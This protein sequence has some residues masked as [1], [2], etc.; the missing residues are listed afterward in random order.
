MIIDVFAHYISPTISKMIE[1]G[2]YARHYRYPAQN[3]D[4]EVRIALMDKYEIDIQAVSQTSPVLMGF[5]PSEAAEICQVSNDDNYRLCQAYPNRFVNIGMISLLDITSALQELERCVSDL[6]CRGITISSNQEGKGLDSPDYY[7]FYE[8]IIKYDLPILIHPSHWESYPLVDMDEGWR[9]MHIFGWPFDTTQA[10]WR[11]IMG[12]VIDRFPALKVVTHHMG[13]MLPYFV[14]RIESTF[15][16]HLNNML[17]RHISEYWVNFY[18]D[19]AVDGTTAAFSCGYAFFGSDRLLYGSD[20]PFGTEAGEAYI[21]DNLAGVRSM[22]LLPEET[23][24]ILGKNAQRF[25][26][27]I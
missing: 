15:N 1:K 16:R 2:K 24:K 20:Y 4:P 14:N 18:G 27:I 7:P 6:D 22:K 11:L 23:K 9:M 5:N 8:R 17:P 10:V 12:G 26:K 13:A 3:A 25:L 21:R 19:T